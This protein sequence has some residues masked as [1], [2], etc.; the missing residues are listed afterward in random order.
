M[1]TTTV[2]YKADLLA[3]SRSVKNILR[4]Y[5]A[6]LLKECELA[7]CQNVIYLRFQKLLKLN[8]LQY[9]FDYTYEDEEDNYG[10]KEHAVDNDHCI[11]SRFRISN[12]YDLDTI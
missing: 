2:S 9:T 8:C 7:L 11:T 5:C 4:L 1:V 10:N 12:S 3:G 6:N